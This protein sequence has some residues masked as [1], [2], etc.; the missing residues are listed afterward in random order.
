VAL[1]V[2]PA[3]ALLLPLVAAPA[4]AV[5]VPPSK[6]LINVLNAVLRFPR[7]FEERPDVDVL[8]LSS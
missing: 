3:V 4:L 1:V 8:S 5:A 2:L 6:A 7:T